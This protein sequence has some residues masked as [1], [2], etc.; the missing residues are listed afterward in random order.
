[1]KIIKVKCDLA[2]KCKFYNPDFPQCF[3]TEHWSIC[4]M[5][6]QHEKQKTVGAKQATNSTPPKTKTP[7]GWQ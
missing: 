1:M 5:R 3:M 4:T 6:S 7:W 2:N